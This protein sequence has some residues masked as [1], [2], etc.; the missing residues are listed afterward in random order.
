L[1]PEPWITKRKTLLEQ[2]MKLVSRMMQ[3]GTLP[4][5]CIKD[6]IIHVNRLEAHTP[7][8]MDLLTL[9]LYKQIPNSQLLSKILK[10]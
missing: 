1:Q 6:G 4:N 5:S 7:E 10:L 8:G 9:E 3:Q 2:R